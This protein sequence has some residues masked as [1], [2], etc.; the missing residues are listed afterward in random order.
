MKDQ[1]A[2]HL[3]QVLSYIIIVVFCVVIGGYED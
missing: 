3:I 2:Q 1:S